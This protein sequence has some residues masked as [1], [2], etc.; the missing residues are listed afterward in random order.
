MEEGK[1]EERKWRKKEG[2]KVE[3]KKQRKESERGRKQ[4]KYPY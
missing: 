3:R 4:L 1:E 2:K